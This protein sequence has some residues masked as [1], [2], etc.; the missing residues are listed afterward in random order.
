MSKL[1]DSDYIDFRET[2]VLMLSYVILCCF[3]HYF[4]GSI[5]RNQN[6]VQTKFK[7]ASSVS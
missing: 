3:Y 6:V 2:V 5:K 4:Y 7:V 1:Y